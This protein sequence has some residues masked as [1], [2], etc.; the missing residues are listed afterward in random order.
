MGRKWREETVEKD[1]ETGD[2]TQKK[3]RTDENI[4]LK[5]EIILSQ[6]DQPVAHHTPADIAREPNCWIEYKGEWE[7]LL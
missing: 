5:E 2:V 4:E 3:V 7:I 1:W 6:E